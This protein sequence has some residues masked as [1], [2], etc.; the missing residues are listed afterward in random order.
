MSSVLAD[1]RLTLKSVAILS[2]L[3][4]FNEH[5]ATIGSKRAGFAA[6]RVEILRIPPLYRG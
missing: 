5:N 2:V 1:R 6:M 4:I 3:A